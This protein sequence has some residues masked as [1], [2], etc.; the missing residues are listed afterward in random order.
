MGLTV[1]KAVYVCVAVAPMAISSPFTWLQV[2][3][4]QRC[5]SVVGGASFDPQNSSSF[6]VVS[7]VDLICSP[8]DPFLTPSSNA[9]ASTTVELARAFWGRKFYPTHLMLL[10]LSRFLLVA[11]YTILKFSVVTNNQRIQSPVLHIGL[12]PGHPLSLLSQPRQVVMDRFSYCIPFLLPIE[13]E[14]QDG[15]EGTLDFGPEAVLTGDVQSTRLIL[16]QPNQFYAINVTAITV[17][18][19]QLGDLLGK[20]VAA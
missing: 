7:S 6:T 5:F 16:E 10:L 12:G 1:S 8:S 13:A 19:A 4:C 14:L 2:P 20:E 15:K 3:E 11:G 17:N 18:G 9:P